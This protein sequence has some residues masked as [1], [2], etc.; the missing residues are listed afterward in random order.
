[1][2]RLDEEESNQYHMAI[3]PA[4]NTTFN[5]PYKL[6]DGW[7]VEEVPRSRGGCIDKVLASL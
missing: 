7:V 1:M 2:L 3:V 5:S 6:P 4:T